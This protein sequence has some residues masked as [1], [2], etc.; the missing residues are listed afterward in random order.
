MMAPLLQ[1]RLVQTRVRQFHHAQFQQDAVRQ[2]TDISAHIVL[3]DS[4]YLKCRVT[5]Q[6]TIGARLA[7]PSFGLPDIGVPHHVLKIA[8]RSAAMADMP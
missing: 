6:S 3:P 8:Y 7:V 1:K 2:K 5:D 4:Q